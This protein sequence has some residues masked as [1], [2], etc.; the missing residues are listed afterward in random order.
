[1]KNEKQK[2]RK[3]PKIQLFLNFR[4]E[5][6]QISNC[7]FKIYGALHDLVPNA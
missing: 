2:L 5:K 1:M 3:H 6:S 4:F 7:N